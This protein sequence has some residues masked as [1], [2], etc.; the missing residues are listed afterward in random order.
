MKN[1]TKIFF[2]KLGMTVLGMTVLGMTVYDRL[3][4]AEFSGFKNIYILYVKKRG[5]KTCSANQ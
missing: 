1:C 3:S 2:S 5:G 4:M